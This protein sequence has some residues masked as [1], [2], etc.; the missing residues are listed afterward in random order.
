MRVT[1]CFVPPPLHS[2]HAVQLPAAAGAHLA[3][4]LRARA[5]DA[6]T[7]FDGRGG[8]YQASILEVGRRGVRVQVG[9]HERLERESPLAVTLLQSLTRAERMDFIVQKATELGTAAIIAWPSR[10]SVVRL[11]ATGL[12]R[13]RE[14]WHGIAISACEQC[15]RN[16]LPAVHVALDLAA[17]C[18]LGAD[19]TSA[20]ELRLMLQPQAVAPLP[21]MLRADGSSGGSIRL[22]I[23]PEGGLEA[24]ELDLAL[25]LGFQACRLGPRVLRAE[26]APLAALAAIQALAGDL[27]S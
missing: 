1:R 21:A 13:R 7:L 20:P 10:R 8:E 22:L 18:A 12:A 5:G 24:D 23:G 2:G 6:L 3:R 14:H 15:G 4:V 27:R 25:Q 11:D 19:T 17:A 26:T 9:A 16:R